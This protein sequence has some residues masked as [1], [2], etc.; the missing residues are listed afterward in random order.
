MNSEHDYKQNA[1]NINVDRDINGTINILNGGI[2]NVLNN[3]R[4]VLFIIK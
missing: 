4:G 2:Q 3:A 1:R